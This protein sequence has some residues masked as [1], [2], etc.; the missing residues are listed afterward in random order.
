MFQHYNLRLNLNCCDN[1]GKVIVDGVVV[2][3]ET[4]ED[5]SGHMSVERLLVHHGRDKQ[6]N[7]ESTNTENNRLKEKT[8][9]AQHFPQHGSK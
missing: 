4:G 7:K 3:E 1:S 6:K 2:K 8:K 5:V 9:A